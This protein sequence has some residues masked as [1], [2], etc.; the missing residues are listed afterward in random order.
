MPAAARTTDDWSQRWP[1]LAR[2]AGIGAE[3]RL[4]L[5]LS[6]GA[7]S[8]L[9][10]HWLAAA[11]PAA[12]IRAAH[13]DHGLRGAES[14]ADAR[15]AAEL[16]RALGV[17][18]VCLRAELEPGP[19]LEARARA[20]RY[21]LL[22]S[23]AQASAHTT[24]LTGHHSDDALE[25][26]LMRWVRGTDLAGLR[27]PR[28]ELV[29]R[30]APGAPAV[31]VVRPLLTLRREEVRALL[32]ARG[33][34]WREDSSNADPRFTRNRT[35]AR[36]L[37]LL[38]ELGGPELID[39]LRAFS[40]AVE[41]LESEFA[42]ATAHLAWRPAPYAAAARGAEERALGGVL[43][44]AELAPLAR[45]LARRVLWRLLT[46]GVGVAPSATVLERVLLDLFAA[47]N[48]RVSLAR[49]WTLLL[50]PRE[51][52]L[53]PP[54]HAPGAPGNV[55]QQ[56]L[57]PFPS[58]G[59]VRLPARGPELA[60]PVPG[61]VTLDDGRRLSAELCAPPP[62]TPPRR[63]EL[64]VELDAAALDGPLTVRFPQPGDRF[65]ALGA[66]GSK[67][68]V[69]FLADRGVPR[70]ERVHVP[71]VTAGTEILWVAGFAPAEARRIQSHTRRRLRLTLHA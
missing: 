23:E 41:S 7:D 13:V 11:R 46:D 1:A 24:I 2:A 43:P 44:R 53:V 66:P 29:W 4:L 61:I 68:L 31:R 55:A 49:G 47:R 30:T 25:T 63:A 52:V 21:R 38:E 65:R 26:V 33:L 70:E 35:R 57:L 60:L 5:A 3:E 48:A 34:A 51:L 14:E 27:G 16:C 6:G 69:R 54:R 8:V 58:G 64:E 67:P 59:P 32:S 62:S 71:L 40:H 18:F 19:N 39:E 36:F 20:E 12:R 10:L 17:P 45:P 56:L 22:V 15:F 28:D 37:P 50:R 9:L 42:R